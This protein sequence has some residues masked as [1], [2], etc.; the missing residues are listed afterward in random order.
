ML[1]AIIATR[2]SEQALVRTLSALVPG[3]TSG[4]LKEVIVADACSRDATEEVADLA[5]CRF[6]KSGALMGERL[7]AAAAIARGHWLLFLTAGALPSENWIDAVESFV[8][9]AERFG[10]T[11]R[12]ATFRSNPAETGL[13][14]MFAGLRFAFAA[15]GRT[16]HGLLIGKQFYGSIGGHP[17]SEDA[18]AALLRRIGQRRVALLPCTITPPAKA[19]NT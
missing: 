7:K 2:E 1:S 3:A 17:A 10:R 19:A 9:T 4:I 6:I 8:A 5:G 16:Q 12:A 13:R 14:R 18:E 11:N 15:A